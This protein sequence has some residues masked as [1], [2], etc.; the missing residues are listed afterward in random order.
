MI[1]KQTLQ[2]TRGELKPFIIRNDMILRDGIIYNTSLVAFCF[3]VFWRRNADKL[4]INS[5]QTYIPTAHTFL[6]FFV[7]SLKCLLTLNNNL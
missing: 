3:E 1:L 5:S 2:S 6:P 4:E 7:K